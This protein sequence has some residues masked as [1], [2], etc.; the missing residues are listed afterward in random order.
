[1]SEANIKRKALK[2]VLINELQRWDFPPSDAEALA[3]SEIRKLPKVIVRRY[4]KQQLDYMRM[5]PKECH[6][7]CRFMQDNDPEGKCKQVSGYWLQSGNYVFHSVVERDGEM[8][9][10]TPIMTSGPD[11]IVFIPDP[12]I[13]WR[14]EGNHWVAYRKGVAVEPGFRSDPI[15]HK[16]VA[17]II[18]A[19]IEAG[20]HPLKA[21][22]P[23][24]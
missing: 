14:T 11:E 3:V 8:F 17:S 10:V 15:E 19:R 22:E 7:N 16:R 4:S 20:M 6:A 18:L 24:F 5:K 23:P 21:G 2:Q 13:E 9:C 12:D 1:M